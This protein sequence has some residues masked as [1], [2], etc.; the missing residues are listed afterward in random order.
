MSGAIKDG[1][2]VYLGV[3]TGDDETD[4]LY[5]SDKAANLR[6]FLDDEG[7]M[8]RSVVELNKEIVV[9][10]Q[11]TLCGDARKGRRPSYAHAADP[12]RARELYRHFIASLKALDLNV[13]EG[14]FGGMMDVTYTNAGP[15]TILLDSRKSF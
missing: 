14:V 2:L 7:K 4:S 12:E 6:I 9:V 10:S 5:L 15:V 8:N 1:L 13:A 11:F 3:C